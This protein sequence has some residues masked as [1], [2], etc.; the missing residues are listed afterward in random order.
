M[1]EENYLNRLKASRKILEERKI[2]A[3][4]FASYP[5]VYY[6]SGLKAS[7][8]YVIVSKEKCFLLTDGRYF[9]RAKKVAPSFMETILIIGDPFK[10]L[11]DFLS[12]LRCETLGFE[13]D[14]V[15]CEFKE[16]LKGKR[17]KLIGISNPLKTIR[18][19]K[20]KEELKRIKEAIKITDKIYYELLNYL[21]PGLSELEIRGKIVELIFKHSAEG[22][23]F[24]SIVAGSANS[25]VP[26]WESSRD[27]LTQ[28]PLL[29]DMGV[30]Y[31]GYCSDFTRTLYLGRAD[32]EFKKIYSLVKTA[33]FKA[34]EKVKVG[35]PIYEIDKAVREYFEK[36]GVL[37]NFTHATGHGIGI[38]IH[39]FPRVYYQKSKK[40]LKEQPLIQEGMVFTIEPGLYFPG[41]YGI[42]LE[43]IV[44]VENGEG[45][46]YS[47]VPLDLLEL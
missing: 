42:R 10:F 19:I 9:E 8:A 26:H 39:E 6:L 41:R 43:N 20:D 33:W 32:S 14:R 45:K 16:R 30:L 44:I 4:I 31:K 5:N 15:A 11:K 3:F 24:P 34:F 35:T 2:S 46:I 40:F 27:P 1:L 21:K 28:G 38:E 29:I 37:S 25:A 13:K 7:H 23:S 17:Y 22:E 12:S 36:K 18:M 47:E